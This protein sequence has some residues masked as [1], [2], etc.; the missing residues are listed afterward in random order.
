M[1]VSMK[2]VDMFW[3]ACAA[4]RTQLCF[5]LSLCWMVVYGNERFT[6]VLSPCVRV[7][8]EMLQDPA[9]LGQPELRTQIRAERQDTSQVHD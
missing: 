1:H 9:G 4:L 6:L 3:S 7:R 8:A 5:S 2:M